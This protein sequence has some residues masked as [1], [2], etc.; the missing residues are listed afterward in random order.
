MMK[1]PPNIKINYLKHNKQGNQL[2][3]HIKCTKKNKR[4][5]NKNFNKFTP[6]K[7]PK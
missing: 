7:N 4:L 5:K 3:A 6:S 1:T 2:K